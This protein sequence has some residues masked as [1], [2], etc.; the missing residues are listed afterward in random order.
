MKR[1]I[2]VT[3]LVISVLLAA[4]SCKSTGGLV[5][6]D[7]FNKIYAKY[8][9]RLILDG[10][11]SYTVKSGDTLVNIA[12]SLY[13]NGYYYPVIMLASK[14][15]V[16]DPDKIQPGMTLTIPDL[17]KNLDNP[18]AKAAMK[19]VILDCAAIENDRGRAETAKG[20]RDHS[21]SL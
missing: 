9:N 17:Q 11:Q 16:L 4:V 7:T 5:T 15:V 6:D 21:N 19:G 3:V 20:L 10:A 14:D 18:G 12:R 13:N 2:L 8:A 1:T